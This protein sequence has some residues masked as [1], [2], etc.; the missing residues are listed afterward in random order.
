MQANG[1]AS[2][3]RRFV[4]KH[5][6]H[7]VGLLVLV[8]I[9]ALVLDMMRLRR[10]IMEYTAVE[11]ARQQL[12]AIEA[13]RSLYTSEVVTRARAAGLEVTHDYRER[14]GAIPL[15]ATMSIMIGERVG[16]QSDGLTT[17]LYSGHPF[18]WRQDQERT[19]FEQEALA[20]FA[21]N[22]SSP[23]YRFEMVGGRYSIRYAEA[24]IMRETCVGCHNSHPQSPKTDWRVG[25]VRGV[26]EV[27]L[28]AEDAGFQSVAVVRERLLLFIFL[29]ALGVA[30][31]YGAGQWIRTPMHS[32][33]ARDGTVK[34]PSREVASPA[35]PAE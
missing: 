2:A 15:P 17:R 8:A 29:G 27:V 24:D 26:L 10:Q 14:E 1:E 7:I 32:S 5:F 33:S 11:A 25:N 18:P 6:A 13:F 22:P 23:F 4:G 21:E 19:D 35:P 20:H 3:M 31:V 16:S 34:A 28:P 30:M 12:H 9:G